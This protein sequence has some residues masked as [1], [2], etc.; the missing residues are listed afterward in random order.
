MITIFSSIDVVESQED[1]Y[2]RILR[3]GCGNTIRDQND[4]KLRQAGLDALQYAID[5]YH[6]PGKADVNCVVNPDGHTLGYAATV[7]CNSYMDRHVSLD[8]CKNC[9]YNAQFRL[10]DKVCPI[11]VGGEME[12]LDCYL[13]YYENESVCHTT[14]HP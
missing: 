13:A 2:E 9:L 3:Q 11:T 5:L 14:P 4:Q 1:K 12:I 7:T 8:D 10:V 6:E